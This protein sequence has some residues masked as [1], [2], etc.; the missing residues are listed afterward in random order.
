M[1]SELTSR[2]ERG[3]GF[4]AAFAAGI[5]IVLILGVCVVLISRHSKSAIPAAKAAKLPFGPAE[6]A[7]APDIHF[8]NIKL[9]KATNFLGEEFTYVQV[10]VTNAGKQSI[11]GLTIQLAFYDPFKQ[12]VLRDSEQ[13]IGP[14]DPPLGPGQPRGLQ[15]T[16]G[17]IPAEWNHENPV[18]RVTGLVLR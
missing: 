4:P 2:R 15:I 12:V 7:Y 1:R 17:G 18:F 10:T 16:L 5:V 3:S 13:L 11:E 9:A 14:A 8:D 6:R